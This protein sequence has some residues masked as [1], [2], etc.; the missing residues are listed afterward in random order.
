MEVEIP[1][2]AWHEAIPRIETNS[3]TRAKRTEEVN[4][5]KKNNKKQNT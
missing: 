5:S 2:I 4:S 1:N 3:G